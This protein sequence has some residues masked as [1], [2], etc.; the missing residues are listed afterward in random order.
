MAHYQSVYSPP[1]S[2]HRALANEWSHVHAAEPLVKPFAAL[3]VVIG[4][5]AATTAAVAA[6]RLKPLMRGWKADVARAEPMLTGA[7]PYDEAELRRILGSLIADSQGVEAGMTGGS[8]Q[9]LDIKSRFS[10]FEADAAETLQSL[11]AKDRAKAHFIRMRS[12]C[13]SCH[14]VFAN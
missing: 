4:L 9:A 12:D 8:A 1:I 7:A 6:P 10:Q 5:C 2:R 13:R 11:G 3:L 14:D